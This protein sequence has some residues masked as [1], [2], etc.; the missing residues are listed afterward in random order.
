MIL[1]VV[2]DFIKT[3]SCMNSFFDFRLFLQGSSPGHSSNNLDRKD[4]NTSTSKPKIIGYRHIFFW[5]DLLT[6]FRGYRTSHPPR[7]GFATN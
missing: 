1:L 5:N 6:D 2:Y 4:K 3:S 7:V